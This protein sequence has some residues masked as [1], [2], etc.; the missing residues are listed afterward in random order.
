MTAVFAPSDPHA[1]DPRDAEIAALRAELAVYQRGLSVATKVCQR[2]AAGDLEPRVLGIESGGVMADLHQG[3]NQLLDMTDAF[4]REAGAA[5]QHASEDKFYRLVLLRGM[6][7]SFRWGAGLINAAVG[8]M[9]AK[10]SQLAELVCS[11]SFRSDDHTSNAVGV[12]HEEMRRLGSLVMRCAEPAQVPAG[13]ALAVDRDVFSDAV[14]AAVM[15]LADQ[16]TE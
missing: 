2:A 15:G 9:A 12:L 7:R 11:N 13:S 6:R 10:T 1:V 8:R 3:I 16:S 4:V 14:T 5:L